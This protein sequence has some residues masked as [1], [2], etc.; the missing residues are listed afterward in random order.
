MPINI[1]VASY[2]VKIHNNGI[3]HIIGIIKL[4]IQHG[5]GNKRNVQIIIIINEI[6]DMIVHKTDIPISINP[7]IAVLTMDRKTDMIKIIVNNKE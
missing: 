2:L 3:I 6:I 7:S 1:K 5:I 4:H